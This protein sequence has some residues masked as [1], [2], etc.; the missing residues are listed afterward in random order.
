MQEV[1]TVRIL[2]EVL[3]PGTYEFAD[4]MSIEDL[5]VTAGGLTEA[6]STAKV[7]VARRIKDARATSDSDTLSY[8]YSFSISDGLVIDGDSAF[9]LQPFDAVYVRKSPRSIMQEGVLVEGEVLFPGY[10]NLTSKKVHLSQIV[11]LAGGLT[12]S[13]SAESTQMERQMDAKEYALYKESLEN[14]LRI[15]KNMQD[16][17]RIQQL[18]AEGEKSYKLVINLAEALENPGTEFDV[19]LEAGDRLYIPR[20]NPV[21]RIYGAVQQ[22]NNVIYQE[23]KGLKYYIN[24]TGGYTDRARRRGTY[25]MYS[26]GSMSKAR[27]LGRSKV[28]PGCDIY[29]PVKEERKNMSTG[30]ILGLGSTAASLATVVMA[31]VNMLK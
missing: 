17:L 2:G 24:Q 23:N 1:Q 7:E 19:V 5:I 25:I 8:S 31:L 15:A 12:S 11:E 9:T 6:A 27:G 28:E 18:L 4:N 21:V 26:N 13:A 3:F 29:V 20:Y 16:S 22:E 14:Q 10:Y 30:E